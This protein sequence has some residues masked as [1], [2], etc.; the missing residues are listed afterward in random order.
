MSMPASCDSVA[1][2]AT[3]SPA[4]GNNPGAGNRTRYR[5]PTSGADIEVASK[6][7]APG[8]S[9]SVSTRAPAGRSNV[10]PKRVNATLSDGAGGAAGA[11][12]AGACVSCAD[13]APGSGASA[14]DRAISAVEPR[15]EKAV[16][17]KVLGANGKS[18]QR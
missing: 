1:S 11:G 7:R 8:A 15:N 13:K 2:I 6:S 10:S 4:S 5:C 16:I 9:R 12:M 14:S 3:L 18:G 17:K